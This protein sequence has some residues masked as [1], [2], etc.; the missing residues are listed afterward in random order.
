MAPYLPLKTIASERDLGNIGA[1]SAAHGRIP[2][3]HADFIWAVDAAD[4]DVARSC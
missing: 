3:R 4:T 1:S 2:D